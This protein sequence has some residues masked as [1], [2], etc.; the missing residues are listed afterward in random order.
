M[1][2]M[3]GRVNMTQAQLTALINERVAAELAAAPAGSIPCG[4]D[5]H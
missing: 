5:T 4:W 2:I 3:S 1:K